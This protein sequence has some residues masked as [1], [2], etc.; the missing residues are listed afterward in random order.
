[1]KQNV[2]TIEFLLLSIALLITIAITIFL[3]ADEWGGNP[4]IPCDGYFTAT[5]EYPTSNA[6]CALTLPP[7]CM[8]INNTE[9]RC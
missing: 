8:W 9:E 5:V 3:I 4:N 2:S 6:T 7:R 1:M